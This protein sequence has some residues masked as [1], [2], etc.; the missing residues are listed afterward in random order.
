[1]ECEVPRRLGFR[2]G[3]K[4]RVI[5]RVQVWTYRPL[6]GWMMKWRDADTDDVME[7]IEPLDEQTAKFLRRLK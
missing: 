1:M 6:H 2:E 5:L 3:W 4:G 7:L